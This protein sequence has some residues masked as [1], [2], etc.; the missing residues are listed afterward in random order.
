MK[1]MLV[2]GSPHENGCT[3][4]ALAEVEKI[5]KEEG[6][7]AERYW[8][9]RDPVGGCTGCGACRKLGRCVM[10]DRVNDFARKAAEADAFVFGSP[11]HYA[12]I[13][14]N[15]SS[16][17]DRVFYS[18]PAKTFRLKPAAVVVSARR[19]GTTAAYEELI[20][21]PGIAEMPIIS[22]CYWNMVHGSRPE[23]VQ[24]DE[25]GLQIMRVLARNMAYVLKCM[26]AGSAAG[27]RRPEQE[28]RAKTNFIR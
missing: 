7:E 9:G 20:K 17:L 23:D 4:A 16:F 11:V 24:K 25:E 19:A 14:G 18:A 21:Y 8:I 1:V 12:G 26:E 15:L 6:I 27:V 2:N 28:P 22:S 5:L 13:S 3:A 10:E